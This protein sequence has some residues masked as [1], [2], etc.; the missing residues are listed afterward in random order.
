MSSVF[1]FFI[2]NLLG[3]DFNAFTLSGMEDIIIDK[4]N[5]V[6]IYPSTSSGLGI[7]KISPPV[8]TAGLNLMVLIKLLLAQ[9]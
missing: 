5:L 7:K 6:N 8:E 2:P 1:P 4:G 9:P 3:P